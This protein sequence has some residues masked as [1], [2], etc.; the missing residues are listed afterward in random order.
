MSARLRAVAS[1]LLVLVIGLI[2]GCA[3]PGN[4]ESDKPKLIREGELVVAMSGEYRPF[5][6]VDN[7]QLTGFDLDIAQA[8]AD[9]MGLKLVPETAGF[10]TL[11]Q[12]TASGRYDMLVA[13]TSATPERAQIVDFADGYYSSGAQLFVKRG[14]ACTSVQDVRGQELGV[15]SG[16]SYEKYLKDNQ[17][18]DRVKTY[19]SD[20]TALQDAA[21]GRLQGA[22]TDQLVGQNQIKEAG[23]DLV[24]CG[25]RLYN[26]TQAPA[27]AKGNPLRGEVNKA[28]AEIIRNGKYAEIST[29]YF[30]QDISGQID[31]A[32]V[33]E[34]MDAA[35][36]E[37]G[38]PSFGELFVKYIPVFVKAAGLTLAITAV[39]LAMALVAGAVIAAMNMSS[40]APLRW[41]AAAWI[42]LIRGT[43]L[44][45]QLF[46]LYFGLTQLVLLS[47]FWAGAIALAVHNSAYIAEIIRSGFGSVPKGLVEASRSLGMSRVQTLRKVQIPLATRAI[48]PVL[49]SQFIIAVKDSSLVA[50]IGMGELFRTAQNMA[51]A[52]YSP[53]NAYLTVSVYYLII[54]LVLTGGVHLL[55][56][57]MN[58]DR[59]AVH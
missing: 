22:V 56:R 1:A 48:L 7:G 32:P 8:L 16:T 24:P 37:Q 13:S 36:T 44:I 15:A 51:A 17:I 5:S 45:A 54:V 9:Q 43:P 34:V 11:V 12:G 49:G 57:R 42:G 46:V 38:G 18:T 58:A 28:L 3:S 2:S 20:I 39:A 50:F 40:I 35:P 26:E 10:S 52:E 4:T 29:K 55:E 47:G 30:G 6:Y 31:N 19:E 53:L 33:R 25:D 59:K 41:L 21:T 14:Q 23:L 27:I